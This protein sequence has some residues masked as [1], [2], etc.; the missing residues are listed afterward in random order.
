[1]IVYNVTIKV[2]E[3]IAIEWLDWIQQEHILD[4]M[5]TGCFTSAKLLRLLEIDDEEGPTYAVQYFAESK[6]D[7]NRYMELHAERM[8]QKS[9][10]KWGNQFIAFRSVMQTVQ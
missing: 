2:N 3:Q 9:F 7:Y 10:D 8:R 5:D 6:S 1:M 4:V